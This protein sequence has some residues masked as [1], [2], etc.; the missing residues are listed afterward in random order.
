MKTRRTTKSV[1]VKFKKKG[2]GTQKFNAKEIT[3]EPVKIKF[4]KFH[5]KQNKE[6]QGKIKQPFV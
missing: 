4:K 1:K 3:T 2:G 5:E 6:I